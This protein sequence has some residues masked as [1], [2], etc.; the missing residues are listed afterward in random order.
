MFQALY[1]SRTE[2]DPSGLHADLEEFVPNKGT[3]IRAVNNPH[4]HRKKRNQRPTRPHLA[5]L[6]SFATSRQISTTNLLD[7]PS[8]LLD[9]LCGD[10]GG[11]ETMNGSLA[12]EGDKWS[13]P[14]PKVP[15][16]SS[17]KALEYIAYGLCSVSGDM[18]LHLRFK[19][20]NDVNGN[21]VQ[22][23]KSGTTCV[24]SRRVSSSLLKT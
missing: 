2:K 5:D 10:C 13:K 17:S 4:A 9:F 1:W 19:G 6:K 21:Y 15:D 11:S 24:D 18:T 7:D 3:M 23:K 16:D 8:S 14:G 12:V 22:R 20:R